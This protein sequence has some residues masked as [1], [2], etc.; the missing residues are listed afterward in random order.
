[1]KLNLIIW[2]CFLSI[3]CNA[4]HNMQHSTD[5]PSKHGML[6]FGNTTLFASHLP[7][8]HSPH[9]YQVILE[10]KCSKK[11][12]K[13]F[14]KDK[15]QHPAYNTYTIEPETFILPDMLLQPRP[16]KV[17]LYRGHFERGGVLI[18]SGITIEIKQIIYYK[19]L[20][21]TALKLPDASYIIFGNSKEQYAIHTISNKPDFEQV[22]EINCNNS[23]WLEQNKYN[24]ISLQSSN[25]PLGVSSNTIP[26]DNHSNVQSITLLRQLYLEW[27]DLKN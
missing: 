19:K 21:S 15:K 5:R 2:G 20:E 11:N 26:V 9:D 3:C 6:V 10:L 14:L 22:I 8:F 12:F 1:M 17:K 13:K 23:A 18:A 24:Q 4:Q 16:F 25:I 27:D 7:L